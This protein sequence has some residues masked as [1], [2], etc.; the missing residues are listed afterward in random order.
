MI[1][2]LQK[3]YSFIH[4][5]ESKDYK[6]SFVFDGISFWPII[7]N[8][9]QIC[10]SEGFFRGGIKLN[11]Y[12]IFSKPFKYITFNPFSNHRR[13]LS[14]EQRSISCDLLFVYEVTDLINIQS[15]FV[16]SNYK[17]RFFR[18][19][20]NNYHVNILSQFKQRNIISNKSVYAPVLPSIFLLEYIFLSVN[21]FKHVSNWKMSLRAL[22]KDVL[23]IF[24]GVELN[25]DSLVP[26]I[27]EILFWKS[28]YKSC[29]NKIKTKAVFNVCYFRFPTNYGL[30][31]ACHDLNIPFVDIQHG[32]PTAQYLNRSKTYNKSHFIPNFYFTWD[33]IHTDKL[34][35]F[36]NSLIKPI[37]G[38][39]FMNSKSNISV[40]TKSNDKL[41][42]LF[43][44]QGLLKQND[45]H[46]LKDL[47]LSIASKYIIV[48]RFHPRISTNYADLIER[49]LQHNDINIIYHYPK[50][51]DLIN[52]IHLSN[53]ALTAY[54]ACSFNVRAHNKFTI[55]CSS[56]AKAHF[57]NDDFFIFNDNL[58]NCFQDLMTINPIESYSN[59]NTRSLSNIYY[60]IS[61]A[62]K[63]E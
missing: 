50:K 26:H 56:D 55:F 46:E 18:E 30:C 33:K 7:R 2:N 8:C 19:F 63:L 29:L 39:D 28:F 16:K 41:K 57:T 25:F 34:L 62:L 49:F 15:S 60:N 53:I 48:F 32:L 43:I 40:V 1:H 23:K 37:T 61:E 12:Q 9:L 24:P 35:S 22:N 21:F 17:D 47:F 38:S 51:H 10:L 58:K 52:S 31:A 4:S 45:L 59:V 54:S 42:L 44:D 11:C 27:I 36:P 20:S 3:V 13:N 6:H 14:F 5:I